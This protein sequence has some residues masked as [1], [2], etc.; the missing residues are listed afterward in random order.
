MKQLHVE[1]FLVKLLGKYSRI[2]PRC[3]VII[4][5]FIWLST[6]S[7]WC[8][9]YGAA[10]CCCAG[11]AHIPFWS[12]PQPQDVMSRHRGANAA[13]FV[14]DGNLTR[15]SVRFREK[16]GLQLGNLTDYPNK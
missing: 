8:S 4:D 10:V 2:L 7:M 12:L 15:L 13:F 5:V 16:I 3:G 14:I 6:I 1:L 11:I 9:H